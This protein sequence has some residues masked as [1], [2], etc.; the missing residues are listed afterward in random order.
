MFNLNT[1]KLVRFYSGADG[2]K[3]GFTDNAKYTMA[4][5]AKRENMRLIAIVL[6]EEVSKT[7]NNETMELLDYGFDNYKIDLIKP[8]NQEIKK[9]DIDKATVQS[10]PILLK[11]D[12]SILSKKTDPS[13]KYDLELELNDINLPIKK[14][15]V[16]GKVNLILNN[17]IIRTSEVISGTN[18]EKVS[19][20]KYF[21]DNLVNIF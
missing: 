14:G 16:L 5:T 19:F 7:R 12:L 10:I 20:T 18:A 15:E 3:T 2:L 4:V 11:E 6:G 1:N 13:V 17:N 9:I 8:K 21:I